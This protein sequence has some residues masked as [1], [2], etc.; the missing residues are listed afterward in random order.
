MVIH[1]IVNREPNG[2]IDHLIDVYVLRLLNLNAPYEIIDKYHS[3][4]NVVI[5]TRR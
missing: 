4:R 1:R 3:R 5:V 2:T